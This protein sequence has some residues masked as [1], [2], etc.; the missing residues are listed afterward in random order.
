MSSIFPHTT[1]NTFWNR[2]HKYKVHF[3]IGKRQSFES[4]QFTSSSSGATQKIMAGAH[5]SFCLKYRL[6]CPSPTYYLLQRPIPNTLWVRWR[7]GGHY[8]TSKRPITSLVCMPPPTDRTQ[9]VATFC[10]LIQDERSRP[11]WVSLCQYALSQ[12]STNHIFVWMMM[13]FSLNKEREEV[14]AMPVGTV[15]FKVMTS[16]LSLVFA[17]SLTQI[18]R[19]SI[20]PYD[21]SFYDRNWSIK[22]KGNIW[23]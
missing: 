14:G 8:A 5:F 21:W 13:F 3:E 17:Y 4:H 1:E 12:K 20:W 16:L 7:C 10:C 19:S 11:Q 23:E 22:R 6:R 2:V 18:S 9:I 15:N